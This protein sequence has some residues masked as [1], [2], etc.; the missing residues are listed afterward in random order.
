MH[1]LKQLSVSSFLRL[2]FAAFTFAFFCSSFIA[3]DRA[4]MFTGLRRI[5]TESSKV[6]TNYFDNGGYAGTFLNAGLVCLV[7]TALYSLPKVKVNATSCLAFL[8]TA[9]FCFWG[10]N[11]LN[12]W[13]GFLGVLLYC[14]VK[15]ENPANQINAM[16]FTTGIC[17]LFT[18]LMIRYPHADVVGFRWQGILLAVAIGLFIGFCLPAGLAHSPKMHKGYDLYSAAVPVGLTAF[19]VRALLYQALGGTLPGGASTDLGVSSWNVANVFCFGVFGLCIV[20]ALVLGCRPK[21]YWRLLRDPGYSVDFSQ[22]YGNAAFLMNVGVYGLF[23][24]LYYNLVGATFNAVT[25]GCIFCM[26][27]CCCSGSHPGNVWPIMVGYVAASFLGKW[28]CVGE[29]Y[30][31]A[32]NAQAIVVGLCFANGLSPI[33]GR[34]GWPFGILAGMLHFTLVTSVPLLHGGFCL[35]NGGFTAAFVCMFFIPVFERF[36]RTKEE[37]KLAKAERTANSQ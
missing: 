29:A 30:T 6:S 19:F 3:P 13:F 26:L 2:L 12:L 11:I 15:R 35:Y 24:V 7:L 33:S 18:D 20:G 5:M 22:K 1:K 25:F 31:Q 8:L 28:F 34:Y 9:G 14:L 10:V 4:E 37:R 27:A 36:F 17:P 32:I 23:I 21:D 16:V